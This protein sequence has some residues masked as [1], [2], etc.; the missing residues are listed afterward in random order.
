MEGSSLSGLFINQRNND[1][2]DRKRHGKQP[3][4][5]NRDEPMN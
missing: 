3:S 5:S 2:N 4:F 1:Q